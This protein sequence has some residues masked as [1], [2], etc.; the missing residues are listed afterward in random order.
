MDFQAT[1][2]SYKNQALLITGPAGIGKTALALQLIE[3]GA[4]LI[5]DDIVDIFI[6]NNVL[7]CKAKQ[8]L[9]GIVEVRGLGLIGQLDVSKPTKVACVIR[10][11]S[12]K[13]ERF[14]EAQMMDLLGKKIPFFDFY[15]CETNFI[16][17]LYLL[18]ILNGE[19]N[20]FK[21]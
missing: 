18:R 7:F 14:P 6:K 9:K 16:Q 13:T 20:F 19:L 21:E 10:L 11:N 4:K 1:A 15:A 3:K 8:E 17:V 12:Q 5:G 2:V